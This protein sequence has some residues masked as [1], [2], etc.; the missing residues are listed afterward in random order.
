MRDGRDSHGQIEL[1]QG[2][3]AMRL[4]KRGFGLQHVQI[5]LPLNH[6]F[7]LCRHPQ[8]KAVGFH[9][10]NGRAGQAASH[11]KFIHANGQL[12]WTH[13]S[14]KG[15]TSEDHRTGHGFVTCFFPCL[16]VKIAASAAY[17]CGHSNHH[18]IGGFQGAAIGAHVLHPCDGVD[19]DHIGGRQGGR[20][21]KARGGNGDGQHV[22]T[23]ALTQQ[24]CALMNHFLAL[25]F[26]D[27]SR[28]NGIG[29]GVVPTRLNVLHRGPHPHA[30]NLAVGGQ[31]T[32]HHRYAV[33]AAFGIDDVGEQKCFAFGLVHAT[34]KLPSNQGM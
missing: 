9:H 29:N 2:H 13:E 4:A 31:S 34:Y 23:V 30:V 1:F 26:G 7:G 27:H 14:H 10:L 18:P 19:G 32:H 8:I 22:K 28:C 5:D 11:I 6:N 21:V 15:R 12:L 16:I 33:L 17:P 25:C 3:M 20:T 24:I